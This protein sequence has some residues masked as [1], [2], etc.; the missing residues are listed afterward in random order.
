MRRK[1]ITILLL[2]IF[3]L[4]FG[5]VS[6]FASETMSVEGNTN[7]KEGESALEFTLLLVDLSGFTEG[8][9]L[10]FQGRL[11][12]DEN[13]FQNIIVEGLNGWT[14][15]YEKT[16]KTFIGETDVANSNIQI[17]KVI[18]TV[19]SGIEPG[20]SGLIRFSNVLLTDG[21]NDYTLNK[22][23][24]VTMEETTPPIDDGEEN[25]PAEDEENPEE[26]PG[27]DNVNNTVNN[28]NSLD[29]T[30]KKPNTNTTTIKGD[31]PDKIT[32]T[33]TTT[34]KTSLPKTGLRNILAV[35]VVLAVISMIVFKIKSR[36]IKY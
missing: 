20:T 31:N 27:E 22:E 23:I 2:I 9:P 36:D 26:Q 34:S 3:I 8:E 17:A 19:K 25:S 32:A 1:I 24:T 13:I 4:I 30:N 16:S 35:L 5:A 28:N 15:N 10:G 7:L 6:S 12:Y 21:T 18:L 14:I 11:T 33:T 29:N